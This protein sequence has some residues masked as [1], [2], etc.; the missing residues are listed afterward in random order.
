MLVRIQPTVLTSLNGE[1][2]KPYIVVAVYMS[3]T[4]EEE[5]SLDT[6]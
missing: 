3:D 1:L 2:Q 5:K 4:V 6:G